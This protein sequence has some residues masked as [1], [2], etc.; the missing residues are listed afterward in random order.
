MGAEMMAGI[1][2]PFNSN[3]GPDQEGDA[4]SFIFCPARGQDR[5]ETQARKRPEI[6]WT[7]ILFPNH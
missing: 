6:P 3:R 2:I 1:C 7:E 4:A 5:P